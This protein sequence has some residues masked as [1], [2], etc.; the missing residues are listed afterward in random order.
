M[1]FNYKFTIKIYLDRERVTHVLIASPE[2]LFI[3]ENIENYIEKSLKERLR[4]RI[5]F[6]DYS[7]TSEGEIEQNLD[8]ISSEKGK[9]IT[10]YRAFRSVLP[11][12]FDL[13]LASRFK[14]TLPS[15]YKLDLSP[16]SLK[17]EN[18]FN[19]NY[20][21]ETKKDIDIKDINLS[22]YLYSDFTKINPSR[23]KPKSGRYGRSYRAHR[24]KASFNIKDYDITPWAEEVVNKIQK[25][26]I[27]SP[28]QDI[29]AEVIVG[30]FIIVE[31]NGEL[32]SVRIVDSSMV[33]FL[34][35]AALKAIKLSSPF[36][37]LP[38][39]F[40]NK[41]LEVYLEFSYSD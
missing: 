5:K 31:K 12:R 26:W 6:S 20:E 10:D 41:N 25:N 33:Q 9:N 37:S 24:G 40:P 30:V 2:E 19:V 17:K 13:D 3:P 35:E 38:E 32:F 1:L 27:I 23:N 11:L 29:K 21:R 36:P 16:D 4:D 15:D 22:E 34:D 7:P 14:L 28:S 18:L 39:D 8:Q